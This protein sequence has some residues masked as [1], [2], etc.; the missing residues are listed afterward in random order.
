MTT[1]GPFSDANLALLLGGKSR[2]WAHQAIFNCVY[3]F[4]QAHFTPLAASTLLFGGQQVELVHAASK[5]VGYS[6]REQVK[7][8]NRLIIGPLGSMSR[9]KNLSLFSFFFF[10]FPTLSRSLMAV[11]H[12]EPADFW[13]RP[14]AN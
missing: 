9:W 13:R 3:T 7:E 10:V 11:C 14:R 4:A 5:S 12:D 1:F 8:S 2:E 6:I